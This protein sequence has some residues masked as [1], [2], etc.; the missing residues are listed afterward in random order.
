MGVFT[1]EEPNT[2]YDFDKAVRSRVTLIATNCIGFDSTLDYVTVEEALVEDFVVGAAVSQ[3][4]AYN[5][6]WESDFR[7][8]NPCGE[9]LAVR[10]EYQPGDTHNTGEPL[11]FRKFGLG[12]GE[13]RIF[14]DI[15]EA[16][17][18]LEG[19][20]ITGSV[21]IESQSDSGCK[22]LSVSRTF[23]STPDGSLGLFVPALP[24]K[25]DGREYL[26]LTGLI[27][28]SHYRSNLRLVNYRDEDVWVSL[29]AH[30]ANGGDQ[31]GEV[32]YAKVLGHSTKQFDDIASRL[33]VEEDLAAF[34]VRVGVGELDVQAFATVVDNL[35][36][37]SVLYLP[38]FHDE[39]RIWLA[40]VASLTGVNDSQWR[41]DL[42]LHNPTGGWLAGGEVEFVV[43]DDPDISYGFEWPLLG[44]NAVKRYLDIV[45]DE[46]NLEETRG[47]IVLTGDD[48]SPAPQVAARTYNLDPSGGGTYGLNLQAF[49]PDDLLRPGE[50]GYIAG[51]SNSEDQ[52]VG[53]RTNMGLLNTD[54]NGWTEVRITLYDIYGVEAAEPYDFQIAPGRLRQFDVFKKLGVGGVTMA[55]SIRIEVTSGGGVA[56]YATEIDNRTQDSIFIPAQSKVVGLPSQ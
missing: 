43:G 39:N 30:R 22:V 51:V 12:A 15:T 53:Y 19:E 54:R 42:W 18:G 29:N 28:N 50:T 11:V 47:Y 24:V 8:F 38:S 26:N 3:D 32:L 44:P 35:T 21:R 46:L 34:S 52:S 4:G 25:R 48:G 20:D 36:G 55:G 5:T 2:R 1:R 14:A 33:G 9:D 13:T 23:N 40:G 7:F 49:A 56:V 17:P 10:I 16:I 27:H 37:D 41:T 31:V 6:R 45:S